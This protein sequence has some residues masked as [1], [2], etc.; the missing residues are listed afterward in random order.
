MIAFGMNKAKSDIKAEVLDK[1]IYRIAEGDKSYLGSLYEATKSAI[2]GFAL[3]LIKNPVDAEDILQDVYVHIYNGAKTY[4]SKGKPMA[5]MLTITRNLAFMKIRDQGKTT[6]LS[7]EDI[8]FVDQPAVTDEDRMVLQAMLNDLNDEERQIV[9]LHSLTGL[10]H[11]EI[12]DLLKMPLSTVLSKY[13]RAIKKLRNILE[14]E[15]ANGR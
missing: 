12:A 15:E 3:S 14:E 2:Y 7:P 11:R 9:V 6:L 1:Y 5:W 13:N 4:K 10:K 8:S